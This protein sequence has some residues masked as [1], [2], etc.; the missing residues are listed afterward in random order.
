MRR[1]LIPILALSFV[2]AG[3]GGDDKP[4]E[5]KEPQNEQEQSVKEPPEEQG[6]VVPALLQDA[7]D[8]AKERNTLVMVD[9][10]AEWW[11]PCK[12]LINETFPDPKVKERLDQ[13]VVL[14]L[15]VD[16]EGAELARHFNVRG[17]PLILFF[18][19]EGEI[20]HRVSGFLEPEP[21][22]EEIKKAVGS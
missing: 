5:P 4:E 22:I 16:N 10:W 19:P 14:K 17:I 11:G 8:E 7:L 18:N 2:F 6:Q 3:C 13:L 1:I 12:R 9:F 15:D 20:V 21:F